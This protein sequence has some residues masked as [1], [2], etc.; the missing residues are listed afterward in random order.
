M[1]SIAGMMIYVILCNS[2]NILLTGVIIEHILTISKLKNGARKM[3]EEMI[4]KIQA[5]DTTSS[6][7]TSYEKS[8]ISLIDCALADIINYNSEGPNSDNI[9]LWVGEKEIKTK[10]LN[11]QSEQITLLTSQVK[12]LTDIVE[13]LS[14]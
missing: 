4:E 1:D 14:K 7:Y 11:L 10:R 13:R 5:I 12:Q 3:F 8:I 9:K 2:Y 6:H